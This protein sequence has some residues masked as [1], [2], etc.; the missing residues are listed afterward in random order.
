MTTLIRYWKVT[1]TDAH[2]EEVWWQMTN[3]FDY[4]KSKLLALQE[5]EANGY[6]FKRLEQFQ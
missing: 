4:E 6:I 5:C 1:A 2:G 3:D